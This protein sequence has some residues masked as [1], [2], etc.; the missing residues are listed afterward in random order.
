MSKA[1]LALAALAFLAAGSATGHAAIGPDRPAAPQEPEISAEVLAQ[2]TP[3]RGGYRIIHQ[4][5][6]R[7]KPMP[8][9]IVR[10]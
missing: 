3:C 5:E 6:S 4:V 8:G 9:V 2:A 1:G 10:C 7:G